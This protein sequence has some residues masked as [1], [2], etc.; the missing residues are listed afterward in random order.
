MWRRKIPI[1]HPELNEVEGE[2]LS[3]NSCG[4]FVTAFAS[5]ATTT[6]IVTKST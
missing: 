2:T 4:L 1:R 3:Q 6:K 5:Q